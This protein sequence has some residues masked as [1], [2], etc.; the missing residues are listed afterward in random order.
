MLIPL[1]GELLSIHCQHYSIFLR[2]INLWEGLMI[3]KVKI[4]DLSK[5]PYSLPEEIGVYKIF[6]GKNFMISFWRGFP[7]PP[8][9]DQPHK[10]EGYG[11]VEETII[12]LK[13]E[14]CI[15]AGD[16]SEIVEAGEAV[17][18]L[19]DEVHQSE[20]PEPVEAFMIVGPP[21]K[22]RT[23][24]SNVEYLTKEDANM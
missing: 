19:G 16:K 8:R 9:K 14:M 22:V 21:V 3:E 15:T 18:Y 13:G 1:K 10:H 23:S 17:S 20:V 7:P 12:S 11:V 6:E 2:I 5:I 4:A 24:G